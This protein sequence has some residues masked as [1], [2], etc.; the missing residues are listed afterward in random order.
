[1]KEASF[2]E[3]ASAKVRRVF[4]RDGE[5]FGEILTEFSTIK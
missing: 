2:G 3:Q 1:M 4:R 5:T